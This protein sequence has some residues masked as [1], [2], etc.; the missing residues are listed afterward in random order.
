MR[1]I[2]TRYAFSG[3]SRLVYQAIGQGSLDLV[4]LP[5]F[6][7]NLDPLWEDPGYARLVKRLSVQPA[8]PVRQAERTKVKDGARVS[9]IAVVQLEDGLIVDQTVVQAGTNSRPGDGARRAA[10]RRSGTSAPRA[11]T[12]G[13]RPNG[14]S[15]W[16]RESKTR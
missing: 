8:D 3:R 6:L 10:D 16:L 15:C 7:S 14:M 1:P 5:G 4:L 2:E 9:C 11:G 13:P 12:H